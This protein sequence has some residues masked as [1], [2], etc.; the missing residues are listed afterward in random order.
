[1]PPMPPRETFES[2]LDRGLPRAERERRRDVRYVFYAMVLGRAE[3]GAL[4]NGERAQFVRYGKQ[5]GLDE[6]ETQLLVSGAEYR[7]AH[8]PQLRLVMP[9][10]EQ[11]ANFLL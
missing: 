9:P 1:M 6:F 2:E 4:S 5:L 11:D 3:R 7:H 10:A 8:A